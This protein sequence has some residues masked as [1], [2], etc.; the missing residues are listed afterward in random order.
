MPAMTPT[1]MGREETSASCGGRLV[2][3]DGRELILQ[4]VTVRAD[5]AGGF[6]RA[7]LEQRFVS[8]Y[9]EPLAL[10]YQLPL[11]ADGAVTG[12]AFR[13]GERRIVGEI[14]RSESARRRFEDAILE[15]RTAGLLEQDRSS[16]FRQEIGNVPPRAEVGA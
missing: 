4:G 14:D 9:D 2:S 8:P 15:G 6:S 3:S 13:V 16:L 11:P 1:A 10:V 5:A 7:V 12:F